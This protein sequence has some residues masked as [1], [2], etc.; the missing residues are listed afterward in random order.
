MCH[1]I[2]ETPLLLWKTRPC[3]SHQVRPALHT[4]WEAVLMVHCLF[5]G[6]ATPEEI[7]GSFSDTLKGEVPLS[8]VDRRTRDGCELAN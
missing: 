5:R 1:L 8:P 4:G 2:W 7:L 6:E 3:S